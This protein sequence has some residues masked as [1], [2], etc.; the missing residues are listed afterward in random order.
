MC[1]EIIS[2]WQEFWHFATSFWRVLL[3]A[4][5]ECNGEVKKNASWLEISSSTIKCA[6]RYLQLYFKCDVC[7]K[8]KFKYRQLT[9]T[10]GHYLFRSGKRNIITVNFLTT[11]VTVT[12]KKVPQSYIFELYDY[13][14]FSIVLWLIGICVTI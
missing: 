4:N 13:L 12:R 6:K 2:K 7:R 10:Y 11:G 14:K 9:G 8:G 3:C 1:K 5:Q